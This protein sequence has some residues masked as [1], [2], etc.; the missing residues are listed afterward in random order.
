MS[1]ALIGHTG[2]VGGNLARQASFDCL[3]NASN[4]HEISGRYFDLVVCAGAP[5]AKWKANQDP[6]GD[7]AA[8]ERLTTPLRTVRAREFILIS[9]VDVYGDPVGVDED[10][11]AVEATPYGAH[12]HEL[13]KFIQRRFEALVV[14]LPALFGP[15]LKKNIVYD[16]L[17]NNQTH[18]IDS[19]GVFQFYSLERLWSDLETARRAGLRLVNFATQP[20]S[21]AEVASAAFGMQF[22]NHLGA[23]YACYDMRSKHAELFGGRDG[24][25]CSRGEVL[26]AMRRFVHQQRESKACA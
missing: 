15:G 18:K 10:S 4:I 16:F 17:H 25:V 13:E 12:R 6:V 3:Y 5:A 8:L 9:T 14:R 20:A 1:T 23:H 11:P 7:R 24:Y 19:R 26:E 21:V 2:F 22:T